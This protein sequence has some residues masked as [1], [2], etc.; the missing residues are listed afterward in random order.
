MVIHPCPHLQ[1]VLLLLKTLGSCEHKTRA[2]EGG[3][4]DAED[5]DWRTLRTGAYAILDTQQS[6]LSIP[7]FVAI[8]QELLQHHVSSRMLSYPPVDGTARI[9]EATAV[10]RTTTP[11]RVAGILGIS[12]FRAC[13]LVFGRVVYPSPH[14]WE[15]RRYRRVRLIFSRKLTSHARDYYQAWHVQPCKSKP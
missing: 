5:L 7:S 11:F 4:R 13:I 12:T 14:S 15:L 10:L 1:E 9:I 2:D 3:S 6:L 8:T